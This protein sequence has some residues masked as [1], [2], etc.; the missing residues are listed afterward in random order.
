LLEEIDALLVQQLQ[1]DGRASFQALGRAVGLTRTAA[2][3]RVSRLLD[4]GVIQVV[5]LSDTAVTG[6][7]VVA[8]LSADVTGSALATAHA[9]ASL[10]SVVFVS[11]T[12]G[13]FPVIADL[14]SPGEADLAADLDRLRAL[15]GIRRIEVVRA[16]ALVR[17]AYRPGPGH[18][19]MNTD[20]V[21]RLLISGLERDGRM[22]YAELAALA[23]LS[24]AATRSRVLRLIRG[25][26]VHVTVLVDAR[27]TGRLARA[28]L[29]ITVRG[30]AQDIAEQ[31]AAIPDITY[32]LTGTG[33]FD[34]IAAADTSSETSL[35][36]TI[37]QIRA[38]RG[39]NR[40]QSWRHLQIVKESYPRITKLDHPQKLDGR[41]IRR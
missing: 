14:R 38:L 6:Q 28:G 19:A 40:V 37:E 4:R 22:T 36:R 5:A 31:I 3:A 12:A 2:R 8:H 20:A 35:L 32:V 13:Q 11:V 29:G 10:P 7:A 34:V 21:D 25:G 30:P 18:R 27:H 16:L 17:D 24:A 41:L 39:V 9:I 15:P 33:R 26:A 1:R 23:G